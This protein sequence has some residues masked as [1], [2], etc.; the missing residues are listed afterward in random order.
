[1]RTT[2]VFAVLFLTLVFTEDAAGWFSRVSDSDRS[3]TG[4]FS[5]VRDN[6]RSKT[7][8]TKQAYQGAG[9]MLKAY[10][11]EDNSLID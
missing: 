2:T 1:M 5:R 4:L 9:D 10:R 6:V 3:N 8:F 7:D 11:Y